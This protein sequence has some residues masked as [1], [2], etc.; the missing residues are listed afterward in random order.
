M[1][2]EGYEPPRDPRLEVIRITPDPGV[3]EANIQP[4]RDW[5]ELADNT[6]FLYEQ[7]RLARLST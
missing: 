4:A 7:A 1:V 2:L 3:L 6:S 5:R